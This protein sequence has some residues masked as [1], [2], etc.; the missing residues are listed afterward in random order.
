MSAL[1]ALAMA[2]SPAVPAEVRRYV[3]AAVAC[4]HWRGEYSPDADREREV[5]AQARASCRGLDAR[6][7]RLL[8]RYRAPSPARR[9][10]EQF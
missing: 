9:L 3:D 10:L 8:R 1:I 7:A 4:E 2:A 5:E 6:R